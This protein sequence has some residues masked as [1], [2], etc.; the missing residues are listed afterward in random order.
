MAIARATSLN[1]VNV[2]SLKKFNPN[3][4]YNVVIFVFLSLPSPKVRDRAG[5]SREKN[6]LNI[7]GRCGNAKKNKTNTDRCKRER[8]ER[9]R[10]MIYRGTYAAPFWRSKNRFWLTRL[11]LCYPTAVTEII[12]KKKKRSSDF[13]F[14]LKFFSV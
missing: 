10:A 9:T 3:G 1:V 11:E 7:E 5:E 8:W 13:C 6:D 14:S 12:D 4:Q 2:C